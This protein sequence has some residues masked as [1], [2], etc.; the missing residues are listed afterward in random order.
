MLDPATG[1]GSGGVEPRRVIR[2]IR[3]QPR[4]PRLPEQLEPYLH[5]AWVAR[6]SGLAETGRDR[7]GDNLRARR[8]ERRRRRIELEVHALEQEVRVV[9]HV[10]DVPAE[11]ELHAVLQREVLV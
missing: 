9:E 6:S 8:V 4:N 2:V 3:V 7:G 5:L 1:G 10:E 11:L